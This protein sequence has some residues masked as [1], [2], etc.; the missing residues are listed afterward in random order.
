[1]RIE[2]E[3]TFANF[4]P[5]ERKWCRKVHIA[6]NKDK[7]I[8]GIPIRIGHHRRSQVHIRTFLYRPV[9]D[10]VL[11]SIATLARFCGEWKL[12]AKPF[13]EALDNLDRRQHRQRLKVT[14]LI[15]RRMWLCRI[16]LYP[17]GK[18][19]DSDYFMFLWARQQR[20]CEFFAKP[21]GT[22]PKKTTGTVP[23]KIPFAILPVSLLPLKFLEVLL[24]QNFRPA[25]G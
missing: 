5:E 4:M 6:T 2:H 18:I 25:H 23:D 21:T 15:K 9:H 10:S 3:R 17:G 7:C 14:I 8:C 16:V 24:Y 12:H 13:V 22:V 11:H 19:V 1:M 20:C